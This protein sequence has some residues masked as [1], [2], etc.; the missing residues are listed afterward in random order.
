MRRPIMSRSKTVGMLIKQTVTFIVAN[1]NLAL[2]NKEIVIYTS[3][4]ILKCKKQEVFCI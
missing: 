3:F 1:S 2:N 4:R